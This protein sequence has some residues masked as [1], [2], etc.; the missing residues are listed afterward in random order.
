MGNWASRA[1]GTF[2]IRCGRRFVLIG[3]A[4]RGLLLAGQAFVA[5]VPLGIVVAGVAGAAGWRTV[6]EHL[7]VRFHLDGG[8]A[9]AVRVLFGHPT[10][11]GG[12]VSILGLVVLFA[13]LLGFT[14]SLQSAYEA[15]WDL[16]GRG[17]AGVVLGAAGVCLLVAQIGVMSFVASALRD[18]PAGPVVTELV[19]FAVAIPVWLVVQYLFLGRRVSAAVLAPGAVVAAAGQAVVCVYSALWMPRLVS[20][21][22]ARYG[23]IGVAFAGV[24]WVIVV[25]FALV[26]AAVIAAEL[27]CEDGERAAEPTTEDWPPP[28]AGAPPRPSRTIRSRTA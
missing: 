15:V 1:A 18:A 20:G 2:P 8:C 21:D 14:R 27:A 28:A 26:A 25:A 4:G 11:P 24:G 9:E 17:M 6:G 3:G 19:R 13:A 10:A 7:V 22:L 16:P 12:V 5:A 23:V